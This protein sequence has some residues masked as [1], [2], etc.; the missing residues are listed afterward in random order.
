MNRDV[1]YWLIATA[2][3]FALAGALVLAI[4]PDDD[5]VC[6]YGFCGRPD[7]LVGIR[8]QQAAARVN[9]ARMLI[10][11][12][13]ATD[14]ALMAR[15]LPTQPATGEPAI[16]FAPEISGAVRTSVRAALDS[17]RIVRAPWRGH[18][19]IGVLVIGD[20]VRKFEGRFI[21]RSGALDV[22]S[23]Y[24][25]Q[26]TGGRCV[27]VIRLREDALQKGIEWSASRPLLDACSLIDAFG[28]PGVAIAATLESG[29]YHA[30]RL[31]LP[32][33]PD[34]ARRGRARYSMASAP[35]LAMYRCAVADDPDCGDLIA[36]SV[37]HRPWER[38]TDNYFA[39]LSLTWSPLA[40]YEN[41]RWQQGAFMDA[42]AAD[43]G[44]ARFEKFWKSNSPIA[45]AY[46]DAS[47][48]SIGDL[49]RSYVG[50]TLFGERPRTGFG[51]RGTNVTSATAGSTLLIAAFIFA[52]L[53]AAT[54]AS[55]RPTV[56]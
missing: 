54:Q 42:I 33:A 7:A 32:A 1:R 10:A 55:R 35:D 14:I 31:Y 56:A 4:E 29:G 47:G 26:A 45:E 2:L 38:Y 43:L 49:I 24:P 39:G 16:W 15:T 52:L 20:T 17:E 6:F 13:E 40:T 46:R 27:A 18:G 30:A 51:M 21:P 12:R 41:D 9:E 34:T 3:T 28:P 53:V 5:N 8:M 37:A 48:R 11:Y 22:R 23:V 19:R 50:I 36:Q 44:P 25:S